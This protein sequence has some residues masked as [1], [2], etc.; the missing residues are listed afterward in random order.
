MNEDV[1]RALIKYYMELRH[2]R[3]LEALRTHT[4]VGSNTTFLKYWKSPELFPMG[5][6]VQIL[7]ALNVPYEERNKLLYRKK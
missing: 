1:F 6:V 5:V 4:T 7:D 2:I 3:T